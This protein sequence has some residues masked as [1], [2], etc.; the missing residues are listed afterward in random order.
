MRMYRINKI[1]SIPSYKE[2]E[3]IEK[4]GKSVY[5]HNDPEELEIN[6]GYFDKE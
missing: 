6:Y 1:W 5:F 2:F 3:V 4:K